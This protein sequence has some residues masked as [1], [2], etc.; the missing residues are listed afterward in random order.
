MR[1]LL[2]LLLAAATISAAEPDRTAKLLEELSNAFGPS[3]YEADVRAIMRREL[4]PYSDR[5]ETD[6]LGSLIAISNKAPG[7]PRVMMAAHMD[8]LGMIV[9]YITPEGY[10]K[11]VTLGGWLDQGIINQRYWISTRKGMVMG[12][13]GLKTH[14]IMQGNERTTLKLRDETWDKLGGA[15]L[16]GSVVQ[17]REAHKEVR[18]DSVDHR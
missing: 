9:R 15:A 5:I 14:H 12:V 1:P 7:A 10:I 2:A 11:F 6:G 3:G 18:C 13:A 17:V 8:E 16:R 4:A